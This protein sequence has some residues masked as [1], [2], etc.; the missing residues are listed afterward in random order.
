[1]TIDFDR[2]YEL[3][4]PVHPDARRNPAYQ[5]YRDAK[6]G[7]FVHFGY[8]SLFGTDMYSSPN[9]ENYREHE[10]GIDRFDPQHLD[11]ERW[12]IAAKEA[13]CRFIVPTAKHHEGF[14]LWDTRTTAFNV[15]NTPCGRDIVSELR[16]ACDTHGVK[17]CLYL[18]QRDWHSRHLPAREGVS[19]DRLW[20]RDDDEADLEK[21]C[22]YIC[23]QLTE[24][25]T[26]YGP[27]G[28]IWLD[29]IEKP[30][31]AWRGRRMYETIKALQP[32]CLVNERAGFGDYLSP[33]W[34]LREDIDPERY[35][36]E[37]SLSIALNGWGWVPGIGAHSSAWCVDTLVTKA[38]CGST[39][40]LNVAPDKD[41]VIP[42]DQHE[43]LR[44]LGRWLAVN[45]DAVYGTEPV[46]LAGL[47]E[48]WRVTR[49]G[50]DH[51]L[52]LRTQPTYDRIRVPGMQ[53]PPAAA[54][55]LGGSELT[56]SQEDDGMLVLAGLPARTDGLAQ[57]VHLAYDA[58]PAV[59]LRPK[60]PRV[61][62]VV[63]LADDT[64][65]ELPARLAN[66]EGL[67]SKG[68][69]L[70]VERLQAPDAA[71]ALPER[72]EA[73]THHDIH[74]LNRWA[75]REREA[76]ATV[77]WRSVHTKLVWHL[78]SD[79]ERRYRVD[80]TLRCPAPYAGS[81]YHLRCGDAELVAAIGGNPE[82]PCIAPDWW[83]G[84]YTLPFVTETAGA[85]T[86]PAGRHRLVMQ[87]RDLAL[88]IG[89]ADV[90]GLRLEPLG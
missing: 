58:S 9:F 80:L 81:P 85:L 51:Y 10:A 88:G 61:E 21:H 42:E 32:D 73:F 79:R 41:G 1:M 31:S 50:D 45:G 15:M 34:H 25:L 64:A 22:D 14:C 63:T 84:W 76:W 36:I 30:E 54:R 77:N 4:A 38:A 78:E 56:V 65:V 26:G 70:R 18:T 16:E 12:V 49:K 43:R 13:G 69:L 3:E 24:L 53:T 86:I 66:I 44:D 90:A 75:T 39:L 28:M 71:L 74:E 46:P 57:V 5:W 68:D 40:L 59:R 52:I 19:G 82:T 72:F 35:I 83:K 20:K 29:G 89:F 60:P 87:P 62:Q 17:L 7:L 33:E 67:G 23:A 6:F 37:S 11:V 2:L 8:G 47:D 55:V 27:I 48:D